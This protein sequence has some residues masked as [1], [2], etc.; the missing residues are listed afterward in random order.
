MEEEECH[1]EEE[2]EKKTEED[3]D[4]VLAK[5]FRKCFDQSGSGCCWKLQAD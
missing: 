3:L 5:L 4:Q 1:E 2:E